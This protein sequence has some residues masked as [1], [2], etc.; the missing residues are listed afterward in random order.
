[1]ILKFS[2]V[3]PW[4]SEGSV[5]SDSFYRQMI[6]L[7]SKK[8]VSLEEYDLK[9]DEHVVIVIEGSHEVLELYYLPILKQFSYP[10]EY[11]YPIDLLNSAES[12]LLDRFI[13]IVINGG[14]IQLKASKRDL[15][16]KYP[17]DLE[18]LD[19]IK[20]D[21]SNF[22]WIM[23]SSE[24]LTYIESTLQQENTK[25]NV[26]SVGSTTLFKKATIAVIIAS[27]NYGPFLAE[28]IESVL[29]QTIPPDEILITD[30]CSTDNT[31]EV[32]MGYTKKYPNLIKYNRNEVNLGIVKNFNKAVSL[33]TSDYICFLGA[34]NRFRSDYLEKTIGI[35]DSNDKCGI[36][37]TD[38]ALFGPRAKIVY[39]G[40]AEER[41]GPVK[42]NFFIINFPDFNHESLSLL[43]AGH[44]FIHGSSMYKRKAFD[45]VGGYIE[46]ESTPEDYNLFHRM[47]KKG[48]SAK[49]AP[50]PLLEYRQHSMDQANIKMISYAELN[51]YKEQYKEKNTIIEEK[52]KYI[53]WLEKQVSERDE[54][55]KW[56]RNQVKERDE[57]IEWLKNQMKEKDSEIRS[58]QE[59][60]EELEGKK[61]IYEGEI[62]EKNKML[63]TL[64]CKKQRIYE[65]ESVIAEKNNT[66]ERMQHNLNKLISQVEVKVALKIRNLFRDNKRM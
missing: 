34:D 32:S 36:A 45:D 63:E 54:G 65:L 55:I 14:K 38:F 64:H 37:Y 31:M 24:D 3:Y 11:F 15:A 10:F 21:D 49:R 41:R 35:L 9:N 13:S 29:Y 20:K 59:Q 8:V 53:T 42:E 48:W 66:I 51:F 61:E 7:N 52:D 44:N 17:P 47:I 50:Y 22:R 2:G 19:S 58:L 6:Q 33:T 12:N 28:A 16:D 5:D 25:Y 18:G 43:D 30:D 40:F 39:D 26:I 46:K 4:A 1:M 62:E 56:L 57:A 60:L 23:D 27:Y